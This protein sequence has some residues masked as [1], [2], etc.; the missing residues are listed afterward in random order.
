VIDGQF[1]DAREEARVREKLRYLAWR[2][3][4]IPRT[5]V[6]DVVQSAIATFLTVRDRYPSAESPHAILIGV[7][8]KK[9][10]EHIHRSAKERRRLEELKGRIL[11]AESSPGRPPGS[12]PSVLDELIRREE[13][14]RILAAIEEL[15]PQVRE[16]FERLLEAEDG[17]ASLIEHYGLNKNTL[18]SRLHTAREQLRRILKQKGVAL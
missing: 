12:S 10:L 11:A 1:E 8:Y 5:E 17:R 15:K 7:F 4:R 16:L 3:Y 18:D 6:D 13:G 9:C 2:R 14:R